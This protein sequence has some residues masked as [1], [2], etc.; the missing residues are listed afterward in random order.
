MP[1]NSVYVHSNL[2]VY[3]IDHSKAMLMLYIWFMFCCRFF[4]LFVPLMY[5]FIY[6]VNPGYL[7]ATYW[8]IE[9]HS[10]Y[11]IFS[12]YIITCDI[13]INYQ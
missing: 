5:V 2:Q 6:L 8:K 7:L 11:D 13:L 10:A 4:V 1:V 3:M 9:A 12:L